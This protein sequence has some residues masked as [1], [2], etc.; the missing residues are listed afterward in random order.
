MT[1]DF[2]IFA[3]L[4]IAVGSAIGGVARFWLGV[5]VAQ[6]AGS[7]FP[8]GT[9]L[10]NIIGSFVIA[11]F[12][13]MTMPDGPRP[14]SALVRLFVMVGLCGGFTTFSAFSLQTIELLRDGENTSA[15]LYI[16]GSVALCLVVTIFGHFLAQ[17]GIRS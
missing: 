15:A 3:T 7:A 6:F 9:L 11:Y 13:T 10:I 14:A 4:W 12:G 16:A 8:Y 17:L 5:A 2:A 1:A